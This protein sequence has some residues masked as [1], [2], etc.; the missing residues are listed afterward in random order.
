LRPADAISSARDFIFAKY[1]KMVDVPLDV[2]ANAI[3]VLMMQVQDWEANM[4]SIAAQASATVSAV[5]T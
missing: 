2:V 4:P 1:S 5:E 3:C